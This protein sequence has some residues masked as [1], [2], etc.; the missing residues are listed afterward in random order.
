MRLK[1]TLTFLAA[2]FLL[3]SCESQNYR[4]LR[5]LTGVWKITRLHFVDTTT[6]KDSLVA[7]VST[8]LSFNLCTKELNKTPSGCDL[9]YLA[10]GASLPFTYQVTGNNTLSI[11]GDRYTGPLQNEFRRVEFILSGGYQIVQLDNNNLRLIGDKLCNVTSG[12]PNTCRY[13]LEIDAVKE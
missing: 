4:P 5:T 6:G 11:N 7:P 8:S 2:I 13:H 10:P 12:Q 9:V 1:L 3:A